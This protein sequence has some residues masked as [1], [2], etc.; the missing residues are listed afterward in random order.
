[1]AP[2]RLRPIDLFVLA[3]ALASAAVVLVQALASPNAAQSRA[4]RLA[5]YALIA[6]FALEFL[7]ALVRHDHRLAYALR[8]WYELLAL[9]PVTSSAILALSWWPLL[10]AAVCLARFGRVVDRLFG[11]EAFHRM[12]DHARAVVVESVADA[13]TLRVLDQTLAVLQKGEYTRNLADA[14]ETHGDAMTA[15]AVEKVKADE[16]VGAIRHVPFFDVAV[17]TSAKVTQRILVDLLRD[18]R[19]DQ[20]VKDIIANNVRQIRAEVAKRESLAA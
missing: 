19:M 15:L 3:L 11:D 2:R 12:V 9:V 4:L 7:F 13:V 10:A 18:P 1:M 8:N 16:E 20:M 14:L 6:L 5:E 17:A